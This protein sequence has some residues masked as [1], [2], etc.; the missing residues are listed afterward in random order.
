MPTLHRATAG[1]L[2]LSLCILA[3]CASDGTKLRKAAYG[4]FGAY[5]V[6]EETAASVVTNP[7]TTRNVV[8]EIQNA[9]RTAAPVA[10]ALYR[11]LVRFAQAQDE[12]KAIYDA[13]GE[14]GEVRLTALAQYMAAL[15][16]SY[17]QS[18]ESIAAL[19]ALVKGR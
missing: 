11:D 17:N 18:A 14:P 8:I 19:V 4:S 15:Q 7:A 5:V 13:G 12:I 3:G 2:A 6:A 16:D 9:T 10:E 1:I